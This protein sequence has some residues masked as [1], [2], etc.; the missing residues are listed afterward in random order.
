[1]F[2]AYV[3]ALFQS[4]SVNGLSSEGVDDSNLSLQGLVVHGNPNHAEGGANGHD[5][6]PAPI[7]GMHKRKVIMQI[8]LPCRSFRQIISDVGTCISNAVFHIS[9]YRCPC[10]IWYI[11]VLIMLH[12]ND[13]LIL[14][15]KQGTRLIITFYRSFNIQ[16]SPSYFRILY[17]SLVR[18]GIYY[19][20]HRSVTNE[21]W[22]LQPGQIIDIRSM[23]NEATRINVE[24]GSGGGVGGGGIPASVSVVIRLPTWHIVFVASSF[25]YSCCAVSAYRNGCSSHWAAMSV[26]TRN[27][28]TWLKWSAG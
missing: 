10:L 19:N 25:D 28:E 6:V 20:S 22:C 17:D 14:P 7:P 1:M 2:T 21:C 15:K 3:G 13:A 12:D 26:I 16:Y 24:E 9:L 4:V 27:G 5:N 11:V 18:T 8:I 23:I